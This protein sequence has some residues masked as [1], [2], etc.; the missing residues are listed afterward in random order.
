M[1]TVLVGPGPLF[2]QGGLRLP[3]LD[4]GE[5]REGDFDSGTTILIFWATWSPRCR[6][7]VERSNAVAGRWQGQ[8]RIALV[9]FQET[10][11]EVRA[12]LADQRPAVP[13]YLDQD[14]RLAKKHAI[15]TLPSLLIL[16]DGRVVFQGRLPADVDQA[17]RE[18]LRPV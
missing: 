11:E 8:A 6:D 1:T 3:G 14:G 16:R 13:V 7:I 4:Q 17:I 10:P 5:L 2:A 18:A 9:D 15:T 12:F